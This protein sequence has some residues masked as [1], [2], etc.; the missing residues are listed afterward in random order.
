M[1]TPRL[2]DLLDAIWHTPDQ[3]FTDLPI[4]VM[5]PRIDNAL[6]DPHFGC[7]C[8]SLQLLFDYGPQV[9]NRVQVRTVL[10]PVKQLNPLV[11]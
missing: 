4:A 5:E 1:S 6:N 8:L 2:D 7:E 9:F 10:R 11:I 3:I